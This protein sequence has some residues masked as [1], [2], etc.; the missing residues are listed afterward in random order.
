MGTFQ[1]RFCSNNLNHVFLDLGSS[2]PANAYLTEKDL[3]KIE[4]Y[5]PLIVYIC[6]NCFLVQLPEFQAPK[7]IF[8]NYSYFSSYSKSWLEHSKNY[9]DSAIEKYNLNSKSRVVEIA[10]NDGYLLKFFKQGG[11]PILGIEPAKNVAKVAI[12]AGIPT[13]DKFFGKNTAIELLEEGLAADLLIGNNVLAHVPD[14]NDFVSGMKILLKEKG[15]I[16]MEFPHLLRLIEGNQFDTIYNEHFSYFTLYSA[17]SIFKHQGLKIISIEEI[18]THGGSLR[19]CATHI[20][21][22]DLPVEKSV[23]NLEKLE[24]ESGLTNLASYLT[25]KDKVNQTKRDIL[26]F[27]IESKEKGNSI[28]AYGAPAKGNTLLNY[29][30]IRSDFIDYTVDVNPHKQGKFLPGTHIPIYHPEKIKDTKPD[31]L[32]ILPWNIGKEITSEMKHVRNWGCRFVTFI[33][34]VRVEN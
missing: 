1:C 32:V 10:S 13:I 8:E 28:V 11:I 30:G 15:C 20:E 14:I 7:E 21:N 22:N 27:L 9:C 6:D 25:F 16:S 29:C 17:S 12:E 18:P 26:K 19:I 5:Y 24:L 3:G 2:P 31:L 33:P 23:N 34:D 4:P